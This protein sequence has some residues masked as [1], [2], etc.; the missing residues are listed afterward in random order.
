MKIRGFFMYEP[1][2]HFDEKFVS[3]SDFRR[4]SEVET[5][6][7]RI[8]NQNFRSKPDSRYKILLEFHSNWRLLVYEA[9]IMHYELL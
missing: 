8:E 1:V 3:S 9:F 7:N 4:L 5:K 2:V 6:E